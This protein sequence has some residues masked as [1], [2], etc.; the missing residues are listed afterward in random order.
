IKDAGKVTHIG[1]M[2]EEFF[3]TFN[4]GVDN[5]HI[6]PTDT[7][8]ISLAAIKALMDIVE[9]QNAK[10]EQ[11]ESSLEQLQQTKN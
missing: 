1:P 7:S 6:S 4:V 3:E 2:A 9:S 11:L 5:K 8:G 10:I